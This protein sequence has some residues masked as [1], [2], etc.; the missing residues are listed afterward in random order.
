[1]RSYPIHPGLVRLGMS[2]TIF[3]RKEG[4][5]ISLLS[6]RKLYNWRLLPTR[7]P[8]ERNSSGSDEASS[9]NDQ[10]LENAPLVTRDKTVD[11]ATSSNIVSTM[12][13]L[14]VGGRTEERRQPMRSCRGL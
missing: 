7:A 3:I 9:D 6:N 14:K 4:V 11:E 1:M 12:A 10:E 2:S 8:E 5:K 13:K